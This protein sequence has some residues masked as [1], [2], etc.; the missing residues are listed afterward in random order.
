VGVYALEFARERERS[1]ENL[2]IKASADLR[3]RRGGSGKDATVERDGYEKR[4]LPDDGRR[5]GS[6][7]LHERTAESYRSDNESSISARYA[8]LWDSP[9]RILSFGRRVQGVERI[10][11]FLFLSTVAR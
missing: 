10:S 8:K 5:S 6:Y 7:Q 3:R 11:C 9:R 1:A 2:Q 4:K